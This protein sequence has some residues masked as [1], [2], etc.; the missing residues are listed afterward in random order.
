MKAGKI[1]YIDSL[2]KLK[3]ICEKELSHCDAFVTLISSWHF[4]NLLA[5]ME[6]KKIKNVFCIITPQ[7]ISSTCFKFRLTPEMISPSID[8]RFSHIFFFTGN[9]EF[10][11]FDQIKFVFRRKKSLAYICP[12]I[13]P[14]LRLLFALSIRPS[15]FWGIDE[16][17]GTYISV[18]EFR[19]SLPKDMNNNSLL[20]SIKDTLIS[21][22][23]IL[24][25]SHIDSYYL[26]LKEQ[27]GTLD[28]N[29]LV[30][31]FLRNQYLKHINRHVK[32]SKPSIIILIDNT[33]VAKIDDIQPLVQAIISL[34]FSSYVIFIK[35]HPNDSIDDFSSISIKYPD[36]KFL[37]STRSAESYV[38][39]Y[40]PH[41]LIGGYS[42]SL[43]V[44]SAIFG[45]KAISYMGL[46]FNEIP[47]SAIYNNQIKY[48]MNAF[49]DNQLIKFPFTISDFLNEIKLLNDEE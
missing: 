48:F 40:N 3:T 14:N 31:P 7:F 16:G 45:I 38:A 11:I 36:V 19:K 29:S 39:E 43:F 15:S 22:L 30:A 42:T 28:I 35:I 27:N 41:F 49:C 4:D 9:L 44:S 26:F 25:F 37:D 21:L 34:L 10:C 24:L 20:T 33:L 1:D 32:K 47:A 13:R 5:I 6:L 8:N 46:Y 17:L 23:N 18:T 2:S 12:G